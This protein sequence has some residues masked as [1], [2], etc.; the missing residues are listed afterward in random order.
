VLRIG[1]DELSD[2]THRA[3]RAAGAIVTN[4]RE[5]SDAAIRT[6]L[7]HRVETVVVVS[8]DDHI[9]LRNALAL[10][11]PGSRRTRISPVWRSIVA[12]TTLAR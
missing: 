7:G 3:L 12:A 4:L 8:K 1:N 6:A 11:S 5:P 2:V 9:S 10:V